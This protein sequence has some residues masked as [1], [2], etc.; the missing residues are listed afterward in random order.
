MSNPLCFHALPIAVQ[1]ALQKLDIENPQQLSNIGAVHAFLLLKK[2]GLTITLSVLWQLAAIE[3][4]CALS[5]I[6][7]NI[8]QSLQ[9]A[10][11]THPPV[12]IFPPQ[13]QMKMLMH[14]ALDAAQTAADNGEVPVGA[15]V[16]KNGNIIAA[17]GNRCIKETYIGAHAEMKALFQAAQVMG[18]YRL[19]GCDLYVTLEPCAMCAGAIIQARISRLI[20][21]LPE[22]KSGAAGSI[23]NLFA[24]R[25]FNAHTAVYGGVLAEKSEQLLRDFFIQKRTKKET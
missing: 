3:R 16:V 23:F 6:D 13:S 10:L 1:A 8:R 7:H 5:A 21:A 20:F 19:E 2:S 11:N 14:A 4:N 18:N 15:V 22:P 12:A 24:N 17:A 9:A 25:Q